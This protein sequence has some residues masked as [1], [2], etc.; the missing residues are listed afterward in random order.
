MA[1]ISKPGAFAGRSEQY[2]LAA[3]GAARRR[4]T[5]MRIARRV[6]CEAGFCEAGEQGARRWE[7]LEKSRPEVTEMRATA[8][9]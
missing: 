2:G 5:A 6:N 4:A 9:R 3:A 8:Q 1:R 7:A